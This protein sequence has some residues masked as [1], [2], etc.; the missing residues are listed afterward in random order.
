M[1]VRT[2]VR[3]ARAEPPAPCARGSAPG[4]HLA[5]P[6]GALPPPCSG[7]SPGPPKVQADRLQAAGGVD[8]M[9]LSDAS[10]NEA[11]T[12]SQATPPVFLDHRPE[13]LPPEGESAAMTLTKAEASAG[14]ASAKQPVDLIVSADYVLPVEPNG[15]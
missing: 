9:W 11:E 2:R 12:A 15:A 7:W 5:A 10:D 14:S 4:V 3:R 8:R 6:A 13:S 1:Q